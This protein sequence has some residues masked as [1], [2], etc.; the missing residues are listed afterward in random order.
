MAKSF[1]LLFVLFAMCCDISIA[2]EIDSKKIGLRGLVTDFNGKPV[3]GTIIY[4]DSVNTNK[5]T[6]KK[7]LYK[8]RVTRGINLIS[9][10]S[11]EHGIYNMTYEGQQEMN[12]SFPEHS[13]K[14]VSE[15]YVLEL[16]YRNPPKLVSGSG[17]INFENDPSVN[18]YSSIFQLLRVRFSG[19]NVIGETVSIR[20]SANSS[21][22]DRVSNEPLYEVDGSIVSSIASI[23]PNRVK[24]IQILKS[25]NSTLYGIRGGNGVIKIKL[26]K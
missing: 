4:V 22:S 1:T 18:G 19:V 14:I 3:K 6:N 15:A 12:F 7:G 16:G 8:L 17:E 20:G 5:K 13:D 9:F 23:P 25:V 26:K 21:I 2:Q 11:S 24:S 10:Y